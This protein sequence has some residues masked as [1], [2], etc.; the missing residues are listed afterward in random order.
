MLLP[1]HMLNFSSLNCLLPPACGWEK[2]G[3]WDTCHVITWRKRLAHERETAERGRDCG[4]RAEFGLA[5]ISYISHMYR[6]VKEKKKRKRHTQ[7]PTKKNLYCKKVR[8]QESVWKRVKIQIFLLEQ[9][10]KEIW[11]EDVN[12]GL[13]NT[14]FGIEIE[15]LK[16]SEDAE[17]VRNTPRLCK[18]SVSVFK[19][20]I[21]IN[22]IINVKWR[23]LE[24]CMHMYIKK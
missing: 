23:M 13:R 19:V 17:K 14:R 15:E 7:T 10:T 20:G 1:L 16:I 2:W 5:E 24:L 3:S 8:R 21:S 18:Y 6:M 12:Q 11:T 9:K 4:T 22:Y